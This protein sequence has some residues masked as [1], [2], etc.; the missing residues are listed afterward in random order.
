MSTSVDGDFESTLERAKLLVHAR[1]GDL[2]M[3]D[4]LTRVASCAPDHQTVVSALSA[5]PPSSP[6]GDYRVQSSIARAAAACALN[7]ST[8][9]GDAEGSARADRFVALA[10]MLDPSSTESLE[11][12]KIVLD[13][14]KGIVQEAEVAQSEAH[15]LH[16]ALKSALT[17][18]AAGDSAAAEAAARAVVNRELITDAAQAAAR[19]ILA[20]FLI[21][22][23]RRD[24]DAKPAKEA[25][26]V[27]AK[28]P[29][30]AGARVADLAAALADAVS[31]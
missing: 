2:K 10:T 1:P 27:L 9:V 4:A 24:G 17:Q 14:R 26:K 31:G 20:S 18:S 12:L 21:E 23:S 16:A 8:V 30:E 29:S 25:I 11:L 19:L 22:R 6:N 5:C 7:A 13:R 3:R 15:E 28:I